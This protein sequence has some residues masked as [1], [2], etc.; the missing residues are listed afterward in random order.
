MASPMAHA[1]CTI[2]M[3]NAYCSTPVPV[4]PARPAAAHTPSPSAMTLGNFDMAGVAVL[5]A[6]F[7]LAV[8]WRIRRA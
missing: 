7:L 3:G 4:V 8:R 6:V 5:I 2:P 1:Y